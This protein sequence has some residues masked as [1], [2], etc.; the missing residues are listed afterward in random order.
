MG[1]VSSRGVLYLVYPKNVAA[2]HKSPNPARFI[3]DLVGVLG[4]SAVVSVVQGGFIT[5]VVR[6]LLLRLQ[7][8][9]TLSANA[10]GFTLRWPP[11]LLS[12]H[13]GSLSIFDLGQFVALLAELGPGLLLAPLA[14]GYAWRRFQA[15]ITW[16]LVWDW[17][18][19]CACSFLCLSN[20]V[21]IAQ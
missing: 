1:R 2:G 4:M 3:S 16:K 5:E 9:A 17:S 13:L 21:L 10:Y 7:G 8:E 11:A 18:P 12:A 20:M 19:G 14:T 15:G 6:G